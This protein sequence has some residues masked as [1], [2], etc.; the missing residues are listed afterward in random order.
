MKN[1]LTKIKLARHISGMILI[2]LVPKLGFA[3]P[4]TFGA[5]FNFTNDAVSRDGGPLTVRSAESEAARD[6]MMEMMKSLCAT[7]GDCSLDERRN[8][9][10]V[11]TYRV[12][13]QDGWWFEIATDPGVVEIQTAASTLDELK[14]H[15]KRIQNDIFGT[16]EQA[17][18][19]DAS[20]I[21]GQSWAG[22]H[23]HIG[24]SSS[25]G[26]DAELFRNFLVDYA[27]HP[28]LGTGI[29]S[30]DWMNAPPLV[31]LPKRNQEHFVWAIRDFDQ[32]KI[33][34]VRSLAK[35]ISITVYD[36]TVD[37]HIAPT[38]KYQAFNV[39]RIVNDGFADEERTIEIRAI[40]PQAS[41]DE[42]IHEVELFQKRLEYLRAHP[43]PIPVK[44]VDPHSLSDREVAARF[45]A[46]V[47]DTGLPFK[48]YEQHLSYRQRL[49]IPEIAEAYR[50]EHRTRAAQSPAGRLGWVAQ[51]FFSSLRYMLGR[52]PTP[53]H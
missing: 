18:L 3:W 6:R 31:G 32:G 1:S 16:A 25:L 45:Y 35:L 27:N 24:A 2:L 34:D 11:T 47:T 12:S 9:Y 44:L 4:P 43:K 7:R 39:T 5:E 42:F 15:E 33:R 14:T 17:G 13:Y 36:T 38:E 53:V 20:R 50:A 22:G 8:H 29:F 21:F 30:N 10:G 41:A 52:G 26:G 37:T 46:Y 51:C 40:H 23:I 49:M 19:A 48:P 28:E